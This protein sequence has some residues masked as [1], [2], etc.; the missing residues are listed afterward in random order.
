MNLTILRF[1]SIGST[2]T[3]ALN[4]AKRGADEGLCVVARRQTAGRGR[5]GRMWISDYD[6]GL[7]FSLVLRPPVENKFLPLVTLMTAIAVFD[8]LAALYRL[9]PDIKWANDVHVNEK[10]IAGILAEMSETSCGLAIVVGIGI[11]LK[12]SNFSPELKETA[13]SIEAETGET[14]NAERLL[15]NL[16]EQLLIYYRIF[17]EKNGAGRIRDEWAK[18]STYFAGKSVRVTLANETLDGT[19]D[20]LEEN[21]ALRV[22]LDG[23]AVKIVQAGDVERLRKVERV[24]QSD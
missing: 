19:T 4:Q 15:E 9:S 2:N 12:S 23:G 6:A 3:E 21:G 11:N 17:Q 18:R 10:K 24:R 13:T 7:Y 22:R 5:H 14:P 20:G 1:D 8:A 16:T